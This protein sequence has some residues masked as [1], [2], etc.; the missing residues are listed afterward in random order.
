MST[1]PLAILGYG[2]RL[3]GGIIDGDSCWRAIAEGRDLVSEIPADRFNAAAFYS[4]RSAAPGKSSSK[5]GGFVDG[6]DLF[7]P[8][9]FGISPREAPHVDPQHRIL[10]E[11]AWEALEMAGIPPSSLAKTNTGA[12]IGLSTTDFS[13]LQ[14]G[15]GP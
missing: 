4:S 9:C 3:P 14:R 13:D 7:E 10:L 12:F 11:T 1:V 15:F 6:Y 2:C 5:W 8:G